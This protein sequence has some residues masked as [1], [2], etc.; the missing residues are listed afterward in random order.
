MG[1]TYLW[2]T[3][4]AIYYLQKQFPTSAEKFIDSILITTPP[5]LSAV[6]E[7]ELLSWKTD[8]QSDLDILQSFINDSIIIEIDA[9]VKIKTAETRKSYKIKLADA[10]IAASALLNNHTLLT[11]NTSDFQAIQELKIINP[12]DV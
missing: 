3:N 4:T 11:R 8:Q 2:D 6:T 9:A 10:I 7:I 5:V 1:V 12:W